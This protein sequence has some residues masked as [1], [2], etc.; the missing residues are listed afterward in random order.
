MVV[1]VPDGYTSWCHSSYT[2]WAGH[3]FGTQIW[4]PNVVPRNRTSRLGK[5]SMFCPV[6]SCFE[7][8]HDST[9]HGRVWWRGR[10]PQ[11]I[12]VVG[13]ETV[14]SCIIMID[15]TLLHIVWGR[16]IKQF[17]LE[18]IL[19]H[20]LS[21]WQGLLVGDLSFKTTMSLLIEWSVLTFS[22]KHP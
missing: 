16:V 4:Y 1:T 19:T 17:Y 11:D 14:R 8:S 15:R 21:N 10:T 20:F 12:F 6:V 5:S 9:L 18:N 22:R 3:K 13:L 7:M 2:S